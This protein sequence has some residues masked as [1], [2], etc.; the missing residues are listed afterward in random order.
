MDQGGGAARR[1]SRPAGA[2]WGGRSRLSDCHCSRSCL[3]SLRGDVDLP[4]VLLL[5]LALAVAV[6]ATGGAAPA[7]A[8][9]VAGFLCATWFFT[10]P[11]HT[12]TIAEPSHLLA[13]V[14]FLAVS[15][16]VGALVSIAAR[17]R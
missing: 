14:V 15:G 17:P 16:T 11:I 2:K 3:S 7:I 12:W 1:C 5:Y 8:A 10:P 6:A 13:L 4:S 9:A